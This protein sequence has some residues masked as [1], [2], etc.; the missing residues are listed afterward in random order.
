MTVWLL[1]FLLFIVL[2]SYMSVLTLIRAKEEDNGNY[3][4]RV[5]NG[6]QSQN[7]GLNLEVKGQKEEWPNPS[8][9]FFSPLNADHT[10]IKAS[11]MLLHFGDIYPWHPGCS[12]VSEMESFGIAAY[13]IFD[14]KLH[15][16][17]L[18]WMDKNWDLWKRE[19]SHPQFF[20][21]TNRQQRR[22]S[23]F[24]TYM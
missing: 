6:N 2:S 18:V 10:T 21:V 7:V 22:Q 11:S 5:E 19:H 23:A 9:S 24:S 13:P 8:L 15:S 16:G 20:L 12:G 14:W 4:M 1:G 3:T 17:I